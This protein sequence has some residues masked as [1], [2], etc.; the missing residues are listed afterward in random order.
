MALIVEDGTMVTGA[1][2]YASVTYANNYNLL[3]G[4]EAW[5]DLDLSVKEQCLRKA[6]QYMQSKYYANWLGSKRLSTQALDWPRDGVVIFGTEYIQPNSII[7]NEIKNA[8]CIL[9]SKASTSALFTDKERA[10]KREKVDVLETEY[11]EYDT[12]EKTYREVESMLGR[13]MT[14]GGSRGLQVVRI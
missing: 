6:T 5:S 7:P 14:G 11:S 3:I 4:N 1:E 8:C 12:T 13:Y 9:A 2:S 10:V